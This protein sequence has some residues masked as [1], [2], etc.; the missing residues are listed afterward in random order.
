MA[1]VSLYNGSPRF[2]IPRFLSFQ[3]PLPCAQKGTRRTTMLLLPYRNLDFKIFFPISTK[4]VHSVSQLFES[5]GCLKLWTCDGDTAS[6]SN[7]STLGIYS[8]Y[9]LQLILSTEALT[10]SSTE[11]FSDFDSSTLTAACSV[12]DKLITFLTCINQLV[13]KVCIL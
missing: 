11:A 8:H 10:N 2:F 4:L 9:Y 7:F 5:C 13:T 12:H 6:R 3:S 1:C